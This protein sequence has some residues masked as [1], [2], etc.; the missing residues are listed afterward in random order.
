[1]G[2]KYLIDNNAV[3]EFLGGTLPSAGS[4][5]MQN[6]CDQ[7]L[8][9]LSVINKIEILGFNVPPSELVVFNEFIQAAQVIP[10]SETVVQQTIEIRKTYKIKLPDAIIAA[11]AMVYGLTLIT[12]N[13]SDFYPIQQLPCIDIHHF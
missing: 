6:I 7:N 9:F 4:D 11:T 8:Q 5:W 10:L 12:R 2:T 1:M 3:I 13:T